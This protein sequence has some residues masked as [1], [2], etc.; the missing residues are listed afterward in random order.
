MLPKLEISTKSKIHNDN[1]YFQ[2]VNFKVDVSLHTQ[3]PLSLQGFDAGHQQYQIAAEKLMLLIC[4]MNMN[5][6]LNT[7]LDKE[8]VEINRDNVISG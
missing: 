2:L 8:T 4:T 6:T 1:N 7:M 5:T 3:T